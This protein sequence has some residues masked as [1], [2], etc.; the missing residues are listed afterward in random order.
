MED[1]SNSDDADDYEPYLNESLQISRLTE[2][3]SDINEPAYL[4]EL[5]PELFLIPNT[6]H[7]EYNIK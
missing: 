7:A 4:N 1:K 2:F 5:I 6:I 3:M